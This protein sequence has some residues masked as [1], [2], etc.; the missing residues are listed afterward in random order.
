MKQFLFKNVFNNILAWGVRAGANICCITFA[1][2]KKD[3][4]FWDFSHDVQKISNSSRLEFVS[5]IA[6]ELIIQ[7]YVDRISAMWDEV[8]LYGF[9][10][11]AH[12]M[13][14]GNILH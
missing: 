11:G 3:K 2:K 4:D 9:S 12:M 1:Y 6:Y 8:D 5:R 14:M 13:G 10:Y 7:V